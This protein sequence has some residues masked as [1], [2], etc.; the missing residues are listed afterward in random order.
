MA[1]MRKKN[2]SGASTSSS[3][4]GAEWKE[5]LIP[6]KHKAGCSFNEEEFQTRI[7]DTLFTPQKIVD[8]LEAANST[9]ERAH[10]KSKKKTSFRPEHKNTKKVLDN[11]FVLQYLEDQR[12]M[13]SEDRYV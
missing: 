7:K 4:M 2:L 1:M 11:P 13:L 9:L 3:N 6:K 10:K 5:T 12:K 8:Q